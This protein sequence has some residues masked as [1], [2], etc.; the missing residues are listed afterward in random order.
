MPG[1]ESTCIRRVKFALL[2]GLGTTSAGTVVVD[3]V[4]TVSETL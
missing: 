4:S 2:V 3:I 1:F